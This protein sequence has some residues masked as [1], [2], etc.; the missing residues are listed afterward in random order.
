MSLE[1]RLSTTF[2]I[3]HRGRFDLLWK[4]ISAVAAQSGKAG[5]IE[6]LVCSQDRALDQTRFLEQ[7]KDFPAHVGAKL[8]EIE[9]GATISVARNLGSREAQG[10]FL[11]FIDADVMLPAN[12]LETMHQLYSN[13]PDVVLFSAVQCS[14]VQKPDTTNKIL[15][16]IRS[17]LSQMNVG[18]TVQALTGQ[19][20]FLSAAVFNRSDKFPEHM[21]TCEDS[22]FTSSLLPSGK[23]L[24]TDLT[25]IVHLGEDQNHWQM[26][27]KE[28]WRGQSNLSS[29]KETPFQ[30]RE[31]PS[32]VFPPVVF[33]GLLL[34][35]GLLLSGFYP[36]A[37]LVLFGALCPVLLYACRLKIK[38][39]V[40]TVVS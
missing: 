30:W 27:R 35:S 39:A 17:D 28:V 26:F 36:G 22:T 34:G 25:Y 2:I 33:L 24:M 1:T 11:A 37:M 9:V 20:L 31:I 13:H 38:P 12:W 4:T 6:I 21:R 7:T 16:R 19:N 18:N 23:L 29:L 3:P 40:E 15:D 32:I 14:A 10:S 8:I 5:D